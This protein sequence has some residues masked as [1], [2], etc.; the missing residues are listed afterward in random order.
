M[1]TLFGRA[2][3]GLVLLTVVLVIANSTVIPT[4]NDTIILLN[5][6]GLDYTM[7]AMKMLL[8]F[9]LAGVMVVYTTT[10]VWR[11]LKNYRSMSTSRATEEHF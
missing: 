3:L 5:R 8:M 7:L 10:S 4:I 6:V 2:V 1:I 9:F 11:A